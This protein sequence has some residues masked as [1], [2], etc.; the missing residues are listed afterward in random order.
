[1]TFPRQVRIRC[2]CG[3]RLD[4]CEL[5]GYEGQVP[6]PVVK[7]GA[8]RSTNERHVAEVNRLLAQ[9]EPGE[10]H[11]GPLV[12]ATYRGAVAANRHRQATRG[13]A[14]LV[15]QSVGGPGS[16]EFACTR[17]KPRKPR[18]WRVNTAKFISRIEQAVRYGRQEIVLG[19]DL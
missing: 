11:L 19:V 5:L 1:M 8:F 15:I 14:P 18:C 7:L 3:A 17:C 4:V 9:A 13:S 6:G 2:E 12:A 10:A 16:I